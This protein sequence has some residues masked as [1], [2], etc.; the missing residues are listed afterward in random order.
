MDGAKHRL[1]QPHDGHGHHDSAIFYLV[2]PL[3]KKSTAMRI[4]DTTGN[5]PEGLTQFFC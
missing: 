3:L 2:V 1:R 5:L 4:T